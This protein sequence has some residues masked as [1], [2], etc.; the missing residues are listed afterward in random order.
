MSQD[1]TSMKLISQS[2]AC[3]SPR[4]QPGLLPHIVQPIKKLEVVKVDLEGLW[5]PQISFQSIIIITMDV[6]EG[7][8]WR[9]ILLLTYSTHPFNYLYRYEDKQCNWDE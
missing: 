1:D 6:D 8:A 7:N 5:Q 4:C 2:P 3:G 9:K